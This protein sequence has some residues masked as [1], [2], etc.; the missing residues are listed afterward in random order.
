MLL[1]LLLLICALISQD[2]NMSLVMISLL[3]ISILVLF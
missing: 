1:S 2:E 3:S